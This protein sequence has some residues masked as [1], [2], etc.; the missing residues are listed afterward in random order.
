MDYVVYITE[1]EARQREFPT[2]QEHRCG[3]PETTKLGGR[4]IAFTIRKTNDQFIATAG[5]GAGRIAANS[6]ELDT[7]R[8]WCEHRAPGCSITE[9]F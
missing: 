8:R 9:D 3:M 7:L 6:P 5:A 2:V 1:R 4:L